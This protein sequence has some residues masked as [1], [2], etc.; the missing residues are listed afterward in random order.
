MADSTKLAVE[1]LALTAAHSGDVRNAR[2]EE[3]DPEQAVWTV[4][5]ARMSSR[6]EHCVPLSPRALALLT[7][8]RQRHD[9]D[10]P[11]DQSPE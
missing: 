7:E 9:R 3:A 1:S 11:E 6:R 8:I 5:A 2:G 10:D 4:P